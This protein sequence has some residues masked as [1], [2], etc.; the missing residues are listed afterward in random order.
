MFDRAKIMKDAWVIVRRFKGNGESVEVLLSRALKSVWW[1]VKLEASVKK[2]VDDKMASDATKIA[3]L[4]KED[5]KNR[6]ILL[7]NSNH[8][9]FAERQ[10]LAD[11]QRAYYA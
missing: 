2:A 4:T 1:N 5:I 10:D 9:T 3:G 11:Y 6:I 7:E 8:L